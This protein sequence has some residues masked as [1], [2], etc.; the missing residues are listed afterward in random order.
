M[1]ATYRDKE[2][3]SNFESFANKIY[4]GIREL[5]PEY[6]EKRAIWEL[7]QNALDTVE[8]NGVIVITKTE[9]GLLFKHNGR[10]FKDDE[11]GGL[12]KQFSV[13]K[14]YGNN[15]KKLGQYGTGFI[16]THVYG[17]KI[18]VNGSILVDDNSYR[19]LKDFEL[20]RDAISL[21]ELTDKLLIQDDFVAELCDDN[22]ASEKTFL[23]YT[24]FE[25]LTSESQLKYVDAMLEYVKK[26]LPYI[27]CFNEKLQSVNLSF[28]STKLKYLK[29]SSSD[30]EVNISI[31]DEVLR[32]PFLKN[33]ENNIKVILPTNDSELE[34]IPKQFLFYPLMETDS[35]GYNFVIHANE[36]KPNRERDYLHKDNAN[37][38][39]QKDVEINHKLLANAFDLVLDKIEEDESTSFIDLVKIK[40]TGLESVFEKDIK[41][42]YINR[43]QG[44]KRLDI[45][46]KKESLDQ[47]FYFDNSIL[48]LDEEYILSLYS[49][50][51][52]FKN[53]PSY[54]AYCNLSSYANNWNESM[55]NIFNTITLTDLGKIIV[56]NC[57]G[58]YYFIEDKLAYK[59]FISVVASDVTLLNTLELI[60]NIHGDLKHFDKLVK[61]EIKEELL[62]N[63]VD[64]INS[65]ISEKYIHSDFDFLENINSY[66]RENFKE[67]FSKFCND[68]LDN[69]SKDKISISLTDFRF[70]SLTESLNKFIGLNKNTKLNFEINTFYNKVFQFSP[71]TNELSSPTVDVN[72]Q[73]AIKLLAYLYIRIFISGD[74][75]ININNLKEIITIMYGNSNLK[76]ELLHKLLCIPNQN[77]CLKSQ[78]DLKKD[79]VKDEEFKDEWDRIVG[80][81]IRKELVQEGFDVFLQH[82]SFVSGQELGSQIEQKL[83]PERKFIPVDKI[84]NKTVLRLIEQISYK[85]STWGQWLR[86][87][88]LVKEEILMDKFQEEETRQSL[89]NIL[90]VNDDKINLL[91]QLAKIDN[92]NDL[93]R[94]GEEK[95][96]EE[97]RKSNHLIYI[98]EIGLK[99]QNIIENEINLSLKEIIEI[100]ESSTDKKLATIEEQN[101]QD[102]IIY[103]SEKPI[104]YIEVKSRWD[105]EG[106]VALSKRQVECC[107][108]NKSNYAVITVNVANY[109]AKNK[110]DMENIS[111]EDLRY[112]VKVNLD[113]GDDFETLIKEN[114]AFEKTV[115]NTKLIEFRGHI[116]QKRIE[117][118]GI[119]FDEFITKLKKHLIDA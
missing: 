68:L 18:I 14:T 76:D 48:S 83:N 5:K 61:W 81:N 36:F 92:L 78:S 63:I 55:D 11:F 1:C 28:N 31:N 66:N 29:I 117:S 9:K 32:I 104:Y 39:L 54:D 33:S 86:E 77:F 71:M 113:L 26:I 72:Y 65:S 62:I 3:R 27:F 98:K 24:S 12:I 116:P 30:N 50:L 59:K 74:I 19:E 69:L 87:I 103:K 84:I 99:I 90:S 10:P 101:G 49:L 22:Q 44:L 112:D 4:T 58:N 41:G 7:F 38:E 118:N 8:E 46:D 2:R 73:P 109:K 35:V 53:L 6:A 111:F 75:V 67:E 70:Q 45:G 25:Y 95:Q 79:N 13:G 107:A 17:K 105:S 108:K 60:P 21:E 64:T 93:I 15:S 91:G 51:S 47:I 23:P 94:A 85:Q 80:G 119:L 37:L 100:I 57:R 52:Q 43:L 20:D 106:I 115:D 102:F 82:S 42:Y 16:S 56:E 89:F 88:N 110:I 114:N 96:K 40:F 97:G 34:N